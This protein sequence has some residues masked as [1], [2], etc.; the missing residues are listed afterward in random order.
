L[1]DSG[2]ERI[3]FR[4]NNNLWN[5]DASADP[6]TGTNGL[7]ISAQPNVNFALWTFATS[8]GR[9]VTL[10]TEAAEFTYAGPS[11]FTS[12]MGEALA[13][14]PIAAQARQ[15]GRRA[16]QAAQAFHRRLE[17]AHRQARRR[18]SVEQAP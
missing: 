12:W 1:R 18:Q 4:K 7:D 17:P 13:A 9:A 6:A 5:N 14:P 16:R 11:G 10:G 3:W 2:A 8:S 15:P